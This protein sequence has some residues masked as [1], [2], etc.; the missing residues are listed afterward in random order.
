MPRYDRYSQSL[1][2]LL[3]QVK[4]TA[5]TMPDGEMTPRLVLEAFLRGAGPV[6]NG[7][8]EANWLV[9]TVPPEPPASPG[10]S[11][12]GQVTLSAAL[13]RDLEEAEAATAGTVTERHLLAAIWPEVQE[14]L[15]ELVKRPDGQ[16]ISD[17]IP[18]PASDAGPTPEPR[19]ATATTELPPLHGPLAT[20]GRDLAATPQ[21]HPLI[22]R[23]RELEELTEILLKVYKPNAI[24]LGDAGVGKTAIVEALAH[25]M[26]SG[27][28]PA[29]LRGKRIID[30]PVAAMV[31]G[32]TFRGQFE[33]RVQAL[34]EQAE[35]DPSIILFIDEIHTLVGAGVNSHQQGDAADLLKPA[36]ARGRLRVIGATTWGEYY[37]SLETDPAVKRRFH[38]VRIEEPSA[39]A[40]AA[41]VAGVMPGLLAHHRLEAG[42][43]II[44]LVISL[45]VSELPSRQF[46][47]KAIDVLDR[48]CASASLAGA[49]RL[50]ASHVRGVIA[51][52]AGIAFTSDSPEF[53]ERLVSLESR[54]KQRVLR[55]DMAVNTVA[56]VVRL[57]KRRLDL[58]TH[59]P[60]GVFLFVGKSG[61]GK[62]ALANA[63]AEMLLGSDEAVIHLDMTGFTEPSSVSKLL[64][65]GPG[66]VNSDEEPPW[67]EKLRKTPSAILLLDELEKAHPDVTKVFLR[68]FDEG[69]LV[70]ARGREYSLANVTVIATSNASVDMDEGGFGL[71]TEVPDDRRIWISGLQDYF[72]PEFLNRFDEIVPF[73][74]LTKGDLGIILRDKIL[75][76]AASKLLGDCNVRLQM[77]DAAIRR[78]SELADSDNFGARELERVF[79]NHVLLPAAEAVHA[80]NHPAAATPGTVMVD[81]TADGSLNVVLRQAN[82]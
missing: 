11:A 44:P 28:V 81:Q 17:P 82:A 34:I 39:E 21:P 25:R 75:P 49:T 14:H 57:C 8:L 40:S 66:Y 42:P 80:V 33:E 47:D 51:N 6:L 9:T 62:T 60:D 38:E 29:A 58:R 1:I 32:A 15:P 69:S 52:Q 72:A 74:P 16:P 64:G 54:L 48:A 45:C 4:V 2:R 18:P 53:R 50:D 43:E 3:Q 76:Q 7:W 41:I 70:D 63:L 59:R 61:V 36:L 67:L 12:S 5:G 37:E 10:P 26:R 27:D 30:L 68:A 79:R 78:I 65:S 13:R 77:S 22:G 55:Q 23:D 24:L 20:Y 56:K 73:E 19:A 46:P 35:S 71:K 31:A